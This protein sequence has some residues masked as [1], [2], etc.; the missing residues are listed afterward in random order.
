V[1]DFEGIKGVSKVHFVDLYSQY[2]EANHIMWIPCLSTFP[3][4]S[5][6]KIIPTLLNPSLS[7]KFLLQYGVWAR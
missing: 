3:L 1:T 2:E 5:Q 6:V 4:L 7:L